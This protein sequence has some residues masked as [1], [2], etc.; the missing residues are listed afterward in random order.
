MP[1]D[2]RVV[3]VKQKNIIWDKKEKHSMQCTN[4]RV[5]LTG[6][7]AHLLFKPRKRISLAD[8]EKATINV[9]VPD[10]TA[11]PQK[12][13]WLTDFIIEVD[14]SDINLD[15]SLGRIKQID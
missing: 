6:V 3:P 4:V 11:K 5:D 13:S 14:V 8:V 10:N 15:T 12:F 1:L 2:L 9:I 7:T